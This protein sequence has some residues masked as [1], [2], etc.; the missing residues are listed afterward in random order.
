MLDRNNMNWQDTKLGGMILG[1]FVV[2]AVVAGLFTFASWRSEQ[3][4]DVPKTTGGSSTHASSPAAPSAPAAP[5][6]TNKASGERLTYA[7]PI[8]SSDHR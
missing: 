4:A 1:G 6:Q 5:T 7:R 2:V 8:A 3:T